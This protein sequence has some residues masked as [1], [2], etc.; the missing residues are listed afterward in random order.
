MTLP[1]KFH[2]APF[3][4]SKCLN[5]PIDNKEDKRLQAV[6]RPEK[7]NNN[8]ESVKPRSSDTSRAA[9]ERHL[10]VIESF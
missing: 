5:E 1:L 6:Y 8:F 10:I 9:K 4:S 3:R 2:A 7:P